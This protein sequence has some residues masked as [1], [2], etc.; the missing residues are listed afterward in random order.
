MRTLRL[1]GN[2]ITVGFL[3]VVWWSGSAR[4]AVNYEIW[5]VDL[6]WLPDYATLGAPAEAGLINNFDIESLRGGA[7]YFTFRFTGYIYIDTPG[8]YT[9]FTSSD[10]GSKLYIGDWEGACAGMGQLMEVVDNDGL[11]GLQE[12]SGT[13][14]LGKGH[15]GIMVTYFE[16]TGG[17]D[18]QVRWQGPGIAKQLIPDSVLEVGLA[19]GFCPPADAVNVLP[20]AVLSWQDLVEDP[21]YVVHFGTEPNLAQM[22]K[23]IDQQ[24]V[25]TYEPELDYGTQYYW[26]V[27]MVDPNE[28][29]TPSLIPGLILG[30]QTAP[31]SPV[32]LVQPQDSLIWPGETATFSVDV[33]SAA[34]AEVSYAWYK[35]GVGPISG[36]T[37]ATLEIPDPQ[38]DDEG[39]Y[40]CV[41]TNEFGSD[42]SASARLKLKKLVGHW[43]FDGDFEDKIAGHHGTP[44]GQTPVF[45]EGIVPADGGPGQAVQFDGLGAP[46]SQAVRISSDGV[47]PQS[48]FTISFWEKTT[49]DTATGYIFSSS[50]GAAGAVG[51]EYIYLWR[52][53]GDTHYVGF[54][55]G[56]DFALHGAMGA[57]PVS[58]QEWH[59]VTFVYDYEQNRYRYYVDAENLTLGTDATTPTPSGFQLVSP[60]EDF[61][62]DFFVGNRENLLRPY[63]GLVDD[64]RIYDF[65]M[66][67]VDIA[68]LYTD[69]VGG[70]VCLE[71]V[72]NDLNGD[73]VVNLE[74]LVILVSAWT[75]CNLLPAEACD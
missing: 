43:P 18:L 48:S 29:G 12:A 6:D 67:D 52:Y 57:V 51:Y 75:E 8:T 14:E 28:G 26:A 27:S 10:D 11:H 21:L 63:L 31:K 58:R 33:L 66:D 41:A 40:Y 23:V 37:G 47:P 24:A 55:V 60:M 68:T 36:A 73:C 59:L 32:V 35:Q 25:N 7:D 34:G 62:A 65:A 13:I 39:L 50:D 19:K 44:V 69:T 64:L 15:H 54:N 9:F 46:L 45:V 74:D 49:S 16:K 30:F 5:D 53:S 4:A 70:Y 17:D 2:V 38:L 56:R 71:E 42:T 1:V 3:C 22:A 72:P 20:G 61:V